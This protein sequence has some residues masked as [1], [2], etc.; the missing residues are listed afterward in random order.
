M[1]TITKGNKLLKSISVIDLFS[2]NASHK[3]CTQSSSMLLAIN[4]GKKKRDNLFSFSFWNVFQTNNQETTVWELYC[5][6]QLH[7]MLRHH[8]FQN[9]CLHIRGEDDDCLIV[10]TLWVYMPNQVF[11]V[12]HLSWV[13]HT[14]LSFQYPEC[15]NLFTQVKNETIF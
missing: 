1:K 6:W 14:M 11:R 13:L 7:S 8:F 12:F 2:I 10:P 5:S 15:N 3:T 9:Y 4:T